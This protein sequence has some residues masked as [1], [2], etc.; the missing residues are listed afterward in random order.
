PID[1]TSCKCV[2]RV[3][4][5]RGKPMSQNLQPAALSSGLAG[6]RIMS[7][8][9][10]PAMKVLLLTHSYSPEHSPP[11]RRW[12]A[13]LQVFTDKGISVCVV[14]PKNGGLPQEN[15][16]GIKVVRYP[17]FGRPKRL[18]LQALRSVLQS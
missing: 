18:A 3:Q 11:Q 10:L 17:S 13:F 16:P 9:N 7:S 15:E 2:R 8:S 6:T 4:V 12:K 14:A 1:L 5:I